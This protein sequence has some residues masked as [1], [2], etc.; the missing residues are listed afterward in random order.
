[1]SFQISSS[2]DVNNR[3]CHKFAFVTAPIFIILR[4]IGTRYVSFGITHKALHFSART[5][6]AITRYR[7]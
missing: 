7:T 3:G 5:A 4:A 6:T 2:K 1:M